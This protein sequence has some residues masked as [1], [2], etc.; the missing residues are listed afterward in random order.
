MA[1]PRRGSSAGAA[2]QEGAFP[3]APATAAQCR[4]CGGIAA[5][6][7]R[8]CWRR[9]A[10]GLGAGGYSGRCTVAF[11]E[12]ILLQVGARRS[13]VDAAARP[14]CHPPCQLPSP[15]ASLC[16]CTV[17]AASLHAASL[18]SRPGCR[19]IGARCRRAAAR[20]GPPWPTW[21]KPLRPASAAPACC[22]LPPCWWGRSLPTATC[23]PA[24]SHRRQRSGRPGPSLL[25]RAMAPRT[26]SQQTALPAAASGAALAAPAAGAQ[27]CQPCWQALTG[28]QRSL[29]SVGRR[30]F[31]CRGTRPAQPA[32]VAVV[33]RRQRRRG[34]WLCC[35]TQ[36]ACWPTAAA[37]TVAATAA[38][39][40]MRGYG[41]S[42]G[43]R[44]RCCSTA[45]S[46]SCCLGWQRRACWWRRCWGRGLVPAAALRRQ[47]RRL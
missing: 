44:P 4:T 11:G 22:P 17:Q 9:W 31:A 27:R 7:L 14:C 46:T 29:R 15:A 21:A 35:C 8:S 16:A 10:L 47:A 2:A 45:G 24:A 33:R 38:A 1:Q 42:R 37:S 43:C 6:A 36:R 39:G 19:G 12:P 5:K 23:R 28:W 34:A 41:W 32:P 25:C 18:P 20:R 30:W 13:P 26:R 40:G 3:P